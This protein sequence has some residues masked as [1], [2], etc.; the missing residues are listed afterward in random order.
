MRHP[1]DPATRYLTTRE[2]ARLLG[3]HPRTVERWARTGRIP[4]GTTPGGGR[5]RIPRGWVLAE[6]AR[7]EAGT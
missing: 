1:A 5:H 4:A 7:R 3:P 6:A 2:A